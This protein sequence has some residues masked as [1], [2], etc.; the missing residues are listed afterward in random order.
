VAP[1]TKLP[2]KLITVDIGHSDV[3]DQEIDAASFN[4]G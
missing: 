4:V 1:P 3:T 2:K